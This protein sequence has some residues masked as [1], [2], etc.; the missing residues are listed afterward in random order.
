MSPLFGRAGA[1]LCLSLC[2]LIIAREAAAG[3][4]LAKTR[5]VVPGAIGEATVRLT[6]A[7]NTPVLVEAWIERD[8]G[9]A[10]AE[11]PVPFDLV[12]PIFRMEPGRGQA[13]RIHRRTPGEA[14]DD[15][16][17][18]FWLNVFE[19]PPLPEG[20]T[21]NA[22]H[23]AV[24]TRIKLFL[25]P[26]GLPGSAGKAPD[27]LAWRLVQGPAPA[28][29]IG[30]PTPYHVTI[31]RVV[32]DEGPLDLRGEMIPPFG[33]VLL[34]LDA[35]TLDGSA[36]QA[37]KRVDMLQKHRRFEFRFLNDSGGVE[38]RIAKLSPAVEP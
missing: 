3:V 6:N 13:L 23:I 16:E 37:G 18:L 25:R 4:V 8:A 31:A 32:L 9:D 2:A 27:K 28:L 17:S 21:S 19:S 22:M 1:A 26:P 11:A 20:A 33:H 24:R 38:R 36:P 29:R 7:R 34:P 12:P 5:V 15:R 35:P 14:P 30:N 10:N